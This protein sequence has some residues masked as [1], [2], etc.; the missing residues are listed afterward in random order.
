MYL[1]YTSPLFIIII[2]LNIISSSQPVPGQKSA[3]LFDVHDPDIKPY[4]QALDKL[5]LLAA[6]IVPA[7]QSG[8]FTF[9]NFH[10]HLVIITVRDNRRAHTDAVFEEDAMTEHELRPLSNGV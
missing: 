7:M 8:Y 9:K 10:T 3:F 5:W 2:T 6:L 1:L 4:L